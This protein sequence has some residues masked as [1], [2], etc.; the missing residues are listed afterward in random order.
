MN[1]GIQETGKFFSALS[2]LFD[3]PAKAL[4]PASTVRNTLIQDPRALP[5]PKDISQTEPLIILVAL[6]GPATG[7]SEAVVTLTEPGSA[8]ALPATWAMITPGGRH[9]LSY[10]SYKHAE[11][12][13]T[14]DAKLSVRG[15]TLTL[16]PNEERR[17]DWVQLLLGTAL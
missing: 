7:G 6:S 13:A 14:I 5:Q 12:V 16:A 2:G 4:T 1:H 17:S 11:T 8:A 9:I 10:S 3:P 15:E